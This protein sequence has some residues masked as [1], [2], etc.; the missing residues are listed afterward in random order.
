MAARHMAARRDICSSPLSS[1]DEAEDAAT[2]PEMDPSPVSKPPRAKPR[3]AG[4]KR[5]PR[6][7][8]AAL[9]PAKKQKQKQVLKR[10]STKE[11]VHDAPQEFVEYLAE[12]L[13]AV[14]QAKFEAEFEGGQGFI[15]KLPTA[16]GSW[17]SKR[18]REQLED[19]IRALGFGSGVSLSRNALRVASL[20][21]DVIVREL[22]LRVPGE[23]KDEEVVEETGTGDARADESPVVEERGENGDY[24]ADP[25]ML[26][27]K[28]Y[29]QKLE[30]Q[31][32]EVV[33][34]SENHRLLSSTQHMAIADAMEDVLAQPSSRRDRRLARR[35]S[36]LGRISGRRMS[37]IA[38]APSSSSF[39]PPMED[40]W[41]WDREMGK[42]SL[43]PVKRRIS[44]GDSRLLQKANTLG[45]SVLH[46]VL[47]SGMVDVKRLKE[48]LRKVSTMWEKIAVMYVSFRFRF[49]CCWGYRF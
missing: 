49:S 9:Q 33:S 18:R 48:V 3:T 45:E 30:S 21:A 12:Q 11:L 37:S 34:Y 10:K 41:V 43:T 46:L 7:K 27:L 4:G 39:L 24:L 23:E 8:E 35:L 22:K 28:K 32:L 47:Y 20:K 14:Q 17:K 19:W 31:K 44:L 29:F 13:S 16:T 5:K 2:F 40:D 26:K 6:A 36:K 15:V 42:M 25:A 1:A 38:L